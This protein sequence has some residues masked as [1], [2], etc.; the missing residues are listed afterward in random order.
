ML[1]YLI[2]NACT[3][4]CSTCKKYIYIKLLYWDKFFG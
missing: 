3:H 1:R 4:I 2:C